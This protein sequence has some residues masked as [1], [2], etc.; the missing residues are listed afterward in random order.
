MAVPYEKVVPV[1]FSHDSPPLLVP[2]ARNT[3]PAKTSKL[4]GSRSKPLDDTVLHVSLDEEEDKSSITHHMWG[5]SLGSD[6]DDQETASPQKEAEEA[7]SHEDVKHCHDIHMQ[8][9]GVAWTN[10]AS[11]KETC[12]P[13]RLLK[14]LQRNLKNKNKVLE[15]RKKN[16][17]SSHSAQ[18][19]KR[20]KVLVSRA[21]KTIKKYAQRG[22]YVPHQNIGRSRFTRSTKTRRKQSKSTK[23]HLSDHKSLKTSLVNKNT[24]SHRTTSAPRQRSGKRVRARGPSAVLKQA[25]QALNA[26]DE[27]TISSQPKNNEKSEEITSAQGHEDPENEIDSC[28]TR[29]TTPSKPNPAAASS[30]PSS[31]PE[32][33]VVHVHHHHHY[34]NDSKLKSYLE[35][36]SSKASTNEVQSKTRANSDG[37]VK[38]KAESAAEDDTDSGARDGN[39]A[40]E[41]IRRKLNASMLSALKERIKTKFGGADNFDE[42]MSQSTEISTDESIEWATPAKLSPDEVA[43]LGLTLS[44]LS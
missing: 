1:V 40:S 8:G 24:T 42:A 19:S 33:D 27:K 38:D 20:T 32:T 37:G 13:R 18:Q 16:I 15:E 7:K 17:A 22:H 29:I 21:T 23:A 10:S 5:I 2:V 41:S 26:E 30:K 35:G 6:E 14:R 12:M 11:A 36:I 9:G 3:E 31:K 39:S 44:Q 25:E 43:A 4:A 28:P 34:L